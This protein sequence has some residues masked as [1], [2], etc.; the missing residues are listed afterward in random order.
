MTTMGGQTSPSPIEQSIE[1]DE[2]H[3]GREPS[4]DDLLAGLGARSDV[5]WNEM[6]PIRRAGRPCMD[7][8][9]RVL[10]DVRVRV[11]RRT[12]DVRRR[13]E[14]LTKEM[15]KQKSNKEEDTVMAMELDK[16]TMI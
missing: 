5:A 9:S 13:A 8:K 7:G 3:F 14:S 1:V 2:T 6:A 12:K 16:M 10:K 11:R 4:A 15:E